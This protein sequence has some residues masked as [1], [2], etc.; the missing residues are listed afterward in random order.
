[1]EG[2]E[3]QKSK[4]ETV[5]NVYFESKD[6]EKMTLKVNTRAKEALM[7]EG[8]LTTNKKVGFYVEVKMQL[9]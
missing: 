4:L 6:G 3:C 5:E 8:R 1:M 2:I 7:S 9:F